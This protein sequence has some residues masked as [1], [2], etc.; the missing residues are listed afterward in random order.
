MLLSSDAINA[1]RFALGMLFFHV[2]FQRFLVLVVPVAFGALEGFAGIS[3]HIPARATSHPRG[4][5]DEVTFGAFFA[6]RP[7]VD[8][9]RAGTDGGALEHVS[10]GSCHVA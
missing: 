1:S 9:I 10:I 4:A 3:R 8:V 2:D 5:E 7:A 6:G